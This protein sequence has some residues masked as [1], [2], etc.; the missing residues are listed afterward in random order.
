VLAALTRG[1]GFKAAG[2]DTTAD[3]NPDYRILIGSDV[4]NLLDNPFITD[5]S[6]NPADRHFEECRDDNHGGSECTYKVIAKTDTLRAAQTYLA[7]DIAWDPK[8]IRGTIRF[9]PAFN[10]MTALNP[11]AK[12]NTSNDKQTNNKGKGNKSPVY[13]YQISGH[14]LQQVAKALSECHRPDPV[15]ADAH[16]PGASGDMLG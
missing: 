14:N 5:Y 3:G 9:A 12:D 8:G 15:H 6:E 11:P 2:D 4:Y 10:A 1:K 16:A 7:R 13:W